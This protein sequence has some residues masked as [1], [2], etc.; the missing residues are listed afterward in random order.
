MLPSTFQYGP[1]SL[2]VT[3]QAVLANADGE[4]ARR[5]LAAQVESLTLELGKLSSDTLILRAELVS[6]IRHTWSCESNSKRRDCIHLS[7][8]SIPSHYKQ[9]LGVGA[10]VP[11][12]ATQSQRSMLCRFF[13]IS[14]A[15]GMIFGAMNMPIYMQQV[16]DYC[17]SCTFRILVVHVASILDRGFESCVEFECGLDRTQRQNNQ[18][19]SLLHIVV[20][21]H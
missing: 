7:F 18:C 11:S 12:K 21:R 14:E 19:Q 2:P 16:Y 9:L 1:I 8:G 6:T 20:Y 17:C 5:Q 13:P 15:H 3:T 4:I 10:Q